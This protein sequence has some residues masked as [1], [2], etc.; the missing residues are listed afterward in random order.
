M[1]KNLIDSIALMKI[2]LILVVAV[3]FH[4]VNLS[5]ADGLED[6]YKMAPPANP[7]AVLVKDSVFGYKTY[8]R[9]EILASGKATSKIIGRS[10]DDT[11]WEES[12]IK[13][14]MPITPEAALKI[15]SVA[16][17]T[18]L[19][20]PI[21]VKADNPVCDSMSSNVYIR[22]LSSNELELFYQYTDECGEKDLRVVGHPYK[23]QVIIAALVAISSLNDL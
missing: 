18:S 1:P 22:N 13:E 17:A 12:H 2:T 3:L 21:I 20:A 11:K 5:A 8:L 16:R 15:S 7:D 23:V 14:L 10:D 19:S 4:A 9:V 6:S